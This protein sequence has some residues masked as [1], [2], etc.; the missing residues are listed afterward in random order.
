MFQWGL[1][2][3]K[4]TFF[5][6]EKLQE[7]WHL[8]LVSSFFKC[9]F[10][11]LMW[12]IKLQ[13]LYLQFYNCLMFSFTCSNMRSRTNESGAALACRGLRNQTTVWTEF[14]S[15]CKSLV[16]FFCLKLRR[17]LIKSPKWCIWRRKQPTFFNCWGRKNTG[18]T[19]ASNNGCIP[20]RWVLSRYF[21]GW[22]KWIDGTLNT[23]Q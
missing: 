10:C 19:D 5:F 13:I 17:S 7:K 21:A 1:Y 2:S 18:V 9:F 20:F 15:V 11:L 6:L 12:N 8:N 16:T 23:S 4:R 14:Q 22:L 3:E